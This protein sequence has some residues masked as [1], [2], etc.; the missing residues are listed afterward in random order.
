MKK[1]KEPFALVH[2]DVLP[3]AIRRTLEAKRLLEA[4]EAGNVQEAVRMAGLS[5]SSFYKYKDAVFAFNAMIREK[6]V[7]ISLV[8]EHKSGV[9]S[10]VLG[11]L[12][13]ENVNVLTVHQSIPL[14]GEA[15][16]SLSV[17]TA[18]A[19]RE[20]EEWIREL[21]GLSGVRRALIVGVGH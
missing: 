21:A 11:F 9:L 6:I 16:V 18:Q 15:T 19:A 8:L 10:Q 12:A 13:S 3:E 2:V 5:R 4:G 20:P 1:S 7:T 14:Q 17:D